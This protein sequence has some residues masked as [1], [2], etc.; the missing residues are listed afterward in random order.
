MVRKI[1]LAVNEHIRMME[2]S[3]NDTEIIIVPPGTYT[4]IRVPYPLEDG[5][6]SVESDWFVLEDNLTDR[7]IVGRAVLGLLNPSVQERGLFT[8]KEVGEKEERGKL[9]RRTRKKKKHLP[10]EV[11][12]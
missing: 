12:C 5:Q 8:I 7:I 3:G 4:M 11:S 6:G 9:S 1:I 2:V 10:E